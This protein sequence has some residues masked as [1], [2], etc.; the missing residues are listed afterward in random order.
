MLDM[1][2]LAYLARLLKTALA[3]RWESIARCAEA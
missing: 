1:C 2:C 3:A